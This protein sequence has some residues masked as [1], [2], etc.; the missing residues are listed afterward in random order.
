MDEDL[1]QLA[2]KTVDTIYRKIRRAT[3]NEFYKFGNNID[4]GADGTVTK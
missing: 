1:K 2:H 3:S 4:I